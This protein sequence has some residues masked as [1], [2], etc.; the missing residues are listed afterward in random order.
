MPQGPSTLG[1]NNSL[2]D[3]RTLTDDF[4]ALI[5]NTD[6]YVE[7]WYDYQ[8]V[9]LGIHGGPDVDGCWTLEVRSASTSTAAQPISQPLIS[10]LKG[11]AETVQASQRQGGGNGVFVTINIDA[12]LFSQSGEASR[13][14]RLLR[15]E[16]FESITLVDDG[17]DDDDGSVYEHRY[18][19]WSAGRAR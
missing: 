17:G 16:G 1:L 2:E 13:A 18:Y 14:E 11:V 19:V 8:G 15:R 4:A 9:I 10:A 6:D 12:E 7:S 5:A 3:P